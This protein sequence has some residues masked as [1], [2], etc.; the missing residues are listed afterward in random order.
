[1]NK[2]LTTHQV[3]EMLQLDTTTVRK[4]I[5]EGIIPATK[6]GHQWRVNCDDLREMFDTKGKDKDCQEL[7]ERSKDNG[8]I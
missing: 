2:L 1:M 3:A 4:Y 6:V 5:R 8:E 7:E